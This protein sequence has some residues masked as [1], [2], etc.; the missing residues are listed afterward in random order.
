LVEEAQLSAV[1][2][3]G[4]DAADIE[5]FATLDGLA[6]ESLMAVKVA[7][8][9]EETPAELVERADLTVDGPEG[10][11]TLLRQFL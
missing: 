3:A 5:A 4:D 9:G 11:V 8:R 1:L 10:L 7:V 6:A 2:Y